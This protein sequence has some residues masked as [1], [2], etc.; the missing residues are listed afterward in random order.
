ME[1][2][3]A[4]GQYYTKYVVTRAAA[5][6]NASVAVGDVKEPTRKPPAVG[7]GPRWKTERGGVGRWSFKFRYLPE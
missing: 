4:L 7:G 3:R 1:Q 5:N 6:E 2:K